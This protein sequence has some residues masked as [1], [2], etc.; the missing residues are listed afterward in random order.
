MD[1]INCIL[2]ICSYTYVLYHIESKSTSYGYSKWHVYWNESASLVSHF[3]DLVFIFNLSKCLAGHTHKEQND[4][5]VQ[6][7]HWQLKTQQYYLLFHSF[8]FRSY[9]VFNSDICKITLTPIW[10]FNVR[11]VRSDCLNIFYCVYLRI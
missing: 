8:S 3:H 4:L 1:R 11:W 9:T 6:R 2:Y 5:T 7:N 10:W